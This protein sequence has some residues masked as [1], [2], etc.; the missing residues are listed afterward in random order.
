MAS[1]QA[2]NAKL[3]SQVIES[4]DKLKQTMQELNGGLRK[5][6]DAAQ[7]FEKKLRDISV[8]VDALA[9]V[10]QEIERCTKLLAEA[11]QELQR[12]ED[13]QR[14]LGAGQ[15]NVSRSEANLRDV[16]LKEQVRLRTFKTRA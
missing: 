10:E 13:V 12:L 8:K 5:E 7:A 9:Q 14:Q 4:P 11:E 2:D 6:Q 15:E 16:G 3:A 1:L